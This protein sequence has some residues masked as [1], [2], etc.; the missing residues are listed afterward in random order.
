MIESHSFA[1]LNIEFLF[2]LMHCLP[3]KTYH[4]HAATQRWNRSGFLTTGTG[5]GP[6]RSVTG[7]GSISTAT[8][9]AVASPWTSLLDSYVNFD[10]FDFYKWS[11][12]NNRISNQQQQYLV[13]GTLKLVN[14][15]EEFKTFDIDNAL[16]AESSI[17][18]KSILLS[19]LK[20]AF[21]IALE[22]FYT[23]WC[24]WTFPKA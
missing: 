21:F 14:T 5:T 18:R 8:T 2:R 22:W 19:L 15:I 13:N 17:V 4:Y 23:R 10:Y 3:K 20:N 24:T 7:T 1:I 9:A 6:D 11:F 12:R 16:K